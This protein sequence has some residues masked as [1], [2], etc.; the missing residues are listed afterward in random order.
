MKSGRLCR[1]DRVGPHS[2][3]S[4][5]RDNLFA[6]VLDVLQNQVSLLLSSIAQV[7]NNSVLQWLENMTTL[8]VL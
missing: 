8:P 2:G 5:S 1:R 4:M 3:A 7:V 6:T